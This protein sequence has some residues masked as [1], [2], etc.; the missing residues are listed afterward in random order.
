MKTKCQGI[1]NKHFK[2]SLSIIRS[3][4]NNSINSNNNIIIN[5]SSIAGKPYKI[6]QPAFQSPHRDSY[7]HREWKNIKY[8]PN[9]DRPQ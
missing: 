5:N 6:K 8:P 9:R 7:P 4:H 2:N 3:S 1:K